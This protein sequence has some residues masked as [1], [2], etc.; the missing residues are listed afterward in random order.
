M[1]QPASGAPQPQRSMDSAFEST[2]TLRG[3]QGICFSSTHCPTKLFLAASM[4]FQWAA[5]CCL[6]CLAVV[7]QDAGFL[8]AFPAGYLSGG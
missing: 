8:N 6:S 5:L 1:R 2:E 4:L 3:P 7:G